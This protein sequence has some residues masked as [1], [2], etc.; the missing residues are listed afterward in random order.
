MCLQG[1]VFDNTQN[2]TTLARCRAKPG[3]NNQNEAQIFFAGGVVTTKLV[4]AA[5]AVVPAVMMDFFLQGTS[6]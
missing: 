2:S 6:L 4:D 3:Y 1:G 5:I